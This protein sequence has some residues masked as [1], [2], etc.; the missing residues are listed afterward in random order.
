[1]GG[2]FG[3]GDSKGDWIVGSGVEKR[4]EGGEGVVIVWREERRV[5]VDVGNATLYI[6]HND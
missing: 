6:N 1:M 2:S 5:G 3:V 4:K